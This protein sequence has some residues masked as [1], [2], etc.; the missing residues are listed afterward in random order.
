MQRSEDCLPVDRITWQ[1]EP[2]CVQGRCMLA[3]NKTREWLIRNFAGS[4]LAGWLV[5]AVV[6]LTALNG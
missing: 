5:I 3:L 2:K 4:L 1:L 6:G